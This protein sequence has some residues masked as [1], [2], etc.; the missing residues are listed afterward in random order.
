MKSTGFVEAGHALAI[1][2]GFVAFAWLMT[3]PAEAVDLVLHGDIASILAILRTFLETGTYYGSPELAWPVGMNP[4]AYPLTNWGSWV[5]LTA[6][7]PFF[8][9]ADFFPFILTAIR[10]KMI[11]AMLAAYWVLRLIGSHRA[12][13]VLAAV[14]FVSI[15]FIA[16]RS[17]QHFFLLDIFVVPLGLALVLAAAGRITMSTP[18]CLA[19][20]L[21]AGCGNLYWIFATAVLLS[22]VI[23]GMMFDSRASAGTKRALLMLAVLLLPFAVFLMMRSL[24]DAVDVP[25]RV[26][27]EQTLYAL[28]F[29]EAFVPW[30]PGITE[31]GFERYWKHVRVGVGE[32]AEFVGYLS[33][34]GFVCAC[35]ALFRRTVLTDP[36][37]PRLQLLGLMG[38]LIL[39]LV[40]FALPFGVGGAFNLFVSPVIRSQN[41]L[42]I[43]IA[44]IG[45]A[46]TCVVVTAWQL[47]LSVRGRLW[48]LLPLVLLAPL[49]LADIDRVWHFPK[50]SDCSRYTDAT[51]CSERLFAQL[52]PVF[53]TIGALGL[54]EIA[55]FPVTPF[56]EAGPRGNRSDYFAFIPHLMEPEDMTVSYSY[57]ML[58]TDDVFRALASLQ[59]RMAGAASTPEAAETLACAGYDAAL[60]D[61]VASERNGKVVEDALRTSGAMLEVQTEDYTLLSIP[62]A[63]AAQP[64]NAVD[65]FAPR[66]TTP[67]D[68]RVDPAIFAE[69]WWDAEDWGRWTSAAEASLVWKSNPDLAATEVVLSLKGF[70]GGSDP[71]RDI[72]VIDGAGRTLFEFSASESDPETTITI[73]LS[74]IADIDGIQRLT[75]TTDDPRSPRDLF[76][77][78]DSRRLAVG[79]T[80]LEFR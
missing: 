42:S 3:G 8:D 58:R 15:D 34:V 33:V 52:A 57:G 18:V 6:L 55:I 4:H 23:V 25:P 74:D 79:L 78:A 56:A 49:T 36:P 22:V 44:F 35:L 53:D 21:I 62:R 54:E 64:A 31:A 7:R 48:P 9:P 24:G 67:E 73:S 37:S 19:L 59:D 71:T 40:V 11:L 12:I 68:G 77:S 20:A 46:A 50:R 13:A 72:A 17:F 10:V 61:R 66:L 45:L 75:I 63:T 29:V 1:A 16:T 2:I 65:C 26:P 38:L 39:F 14:S 27:E 51:N 28:R 30:I 69:G 32:G 47:R 5:I 76:G 80:R 41:R 43:P 70:V 60:I